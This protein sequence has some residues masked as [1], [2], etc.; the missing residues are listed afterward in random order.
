VRV[1]RILVIIILIALF[2]LPAPNSGEEQR[3]RFIYPRLGNPCPVLPGMS[4]NITLTAPSE[5][6]G[7]VME[8]YSLAVE[9]GSLALLNYSLPLEGIWSEGWRWRIQVRVPEDMRPAL[10]W[11]RAIYRLGGGLNFLEEPESL[12]ILNGWPEELTI[13]QLTDT[14]IG[15]QAESSM[16]T[17]TGLLMAKLF[18]ASIIMHTGDVTDTATDSQAMEF[19]SLL[20]NYSLGTPK[21]IIPGNHDRKTE[22]YENYIGDRNYAVDVGSFS[23]IGLDTGDEGYIGLELIGWANS[24]LSSMRGRVKIVMFHHP[25][26]DGSIYGTLDFNGTLSR[27]WLYSSWR[28]VYEYASTLLKVLMDNNVSVV[29][30]GHIHTDRVLQFRYLNRTIY[31]VTTSTTG[32]G[33]PEYNGVRLLRVG[34]DGSVDISTPPWRGLEGYPNSIPVEPVASI[35]SA[36]EVRL[37]GERALFRSF[38]STDGSSLTLSLNLPFDWLVL[39]G[40]IILPISGRISKDA[41][42]LY[43]SRVE[44]QSSARLL[45]SLSALGSN[46]FLVDLGLKGPS[47]LLFTLSSFK[48][49]T[50]PSASIAYLTPSTPPA[51]TPITAYLQSRDDGWGVLSVTLIEELRVGDKVELK[52]YPANKERGDLYSVRLPGYPPGSNIT[53][54][55]VAL[56]AALLEGR[57]PPLAIS[58][59]PP[60]APSFA[61]KALNISKEVVEPGEE[62]TIG[63]TL[64]NVGNAQG[65]HRVSLKVNG[66]ELQS[67]DVE[68][69][70][71]SEKPLEFKLRLAGVGTYIIELDGIARTVKVIPPPEQPTGFPAHYIVIAVILVSLIAVL[72]LYMVRRKR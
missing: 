60:P 19:R 48:D 40:R 16:R 32:A 5:S 72:A 9:G 26:F 4:L 8:A 69:P 21:F 41:Y 65:S 52:D 25:L 7:W 23:I 12:W 11:I 18:N 28:S 27:S 50:P 46:Y 13:L 1:T 53:L 62:I 59:P 70:P 45:A 31:F 2:P 57:S 14:H 29:L 3:P 63:A 24:T 43:P 35:T 55:C 64:A 49:V 42:A 51:G 67:R 39:G 44:N 15:Y 37:A 33:R 56:D 54:I 10:Y 36:G 68:L 47:S 6:S 38:Y 58:F 17:L 61:L 20:L 22:A 34:R 30:S 71:G 66:T